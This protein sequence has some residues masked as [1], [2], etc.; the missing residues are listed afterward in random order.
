MGD[1]VESRR[2]YF[3]VVLDKR[4]LNKE[5][6]YPVKLRVTFN[7]KRCYY[8]V[9][10][11]D[12][13][14]ATWDKMNSYLKNKNVRLTQDERDFIEIVVPAKEA[15]A[16]SVGEGITPFLFEKFKDAYFTAAGDKR[17]VFNSMEGYIR[18]LNNEERYGT[19][20][21]YQCALN[22]L[23]EFH[24]NSTLD[25]LEIDKSWLTRYENWM[26]AKSKSKTTV[27]IYL[28]SLRTIMNEARECGIITQENYPFGK[29]RQK[30]SIPTGRNIKKALRKDDV[31]RIMNF[32]CSEENFQG[33]ARDYWMFSFL[34]NGLNMKDLIA[35]KYENVQGDRLFYRR[36]KSQNTKAVGREIKVTLRP[37]ARAIIEK[38]GQTNRAPGNYIF[39]IL[40]S[41]LSEV[42]VFKIS[43]GFTKKVNKY[44]KLIGEELD[45]PLKLTTYVAR[46][47]FAS[48]MKKT[49]STEKIQEMLGHESPKTTQGYIDST[50]DED[51]DHAYDSLL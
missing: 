39:P 10:L 44:M 37:E 46:H 9:G 32:E 11:R 51:Y 28:R 24:G 29:S 43:L 42:E 15:K 47:S 38:R 50:V 18:V 30:Y 2:P 41:S 22:S 31:R 20:S 23:K 35:L 1:L 4:R 36:K 8:S 34:A 40:N 6:K 17:D 3:K 12:L 48:I 33:Q 25:I 19:E 5:N 49:Q 14:E 13:E 27:G 45:L 7:R 16:V 26:I 21:S